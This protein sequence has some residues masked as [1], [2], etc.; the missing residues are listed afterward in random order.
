MTSVAPQSV[1]ATA[2]VLSY[3]ERARKG[4]SVQPSTV[5]RSDPPH[6]NAESSSIPVVKVRNDAIWPS[7]VSADLDSELPSG[8]RAPSK[9]PAVSAWATRPQPQSGSR[10]PSESAS[11]NN[12]STKVAN[13]TTSV[14][15]ASLQNGNLETESSLVDTTAWPDVTESMALT[16][17]KNEKHSGEPSAAS[18]PQKKDKRKW[19][20]A[21]DIQAAFDAN[22]THIG[23]RKNNSKSASHS[24]T[25]SQSSTSNSMVHSLRSSPR[26]HDRRNLSEENGPTTSNSD[27][28]H[29]APADHK[30][31]SHPVDYIHHQ[32]LTWS[33]TPLTIIDGLRHPNLSR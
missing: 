27:V 25:R 3:A 12:R 24:Q 15:T 5:Q 22:R 21:T 32:H 1:N 13:N 20:P 31:R 17:H 29:P 26:S 30:L 7:V 19:L 2:P 23:P 8:V 9:V 16:S 10:A 11:L 6:S 33:Q 28:S 14:S 4:K 18:S